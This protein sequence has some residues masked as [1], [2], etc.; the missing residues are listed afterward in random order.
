MPAELVAH[1]GK[2]RGDRTVSKGLMMRILSETGIVLPIGSRK[3]NESQKSH[4]QKNIILH[5]M[6]GWLDKSTCK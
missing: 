5:S 1:K 4:S 2:P 3:L 6:Y